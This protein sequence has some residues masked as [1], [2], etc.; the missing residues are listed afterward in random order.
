MTVGMFSPYLPK[1]FGGGERHFLTTAAYLSQQHS[2]EILVAEIPS[3]LDDRINTYQ[4]R[5]DLDLSAITWRASKLASV[6]QSAWATWR[7]TAQYDAFFYLTDGSIFANG[8]RH[9]VLHVQIPFSQPLSFV[10]R[11]KLKTWQVLN[12]NSEFT[13]KIIE[14]AWQRS[15]DVVHA[16]FVDTANIPEKLPPKTNDILT[17]GRFVAPN[18]AGQNKRQDIMVNAFITGCVEKRWPRGTTLH[19]VG[20]LEPGDHHTAFLK[21]LQKKA[22]GYPIEFH[23]DVDNQTVL[24][25]YAQSKVYWHATGFGL[26]DVKHPE[27]TEHFGMTPIEAMAWSCIPV[28]VPKGGLTETIEPNVTGLTYQTEAELLEQTSKILKFSESELAKWQSRIR[29]AAQRY[30]LPRFCQTIDT[31]I[32]TPQSL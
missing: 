10:N 1:H 26:D 2:V 5:F 13:K 16:P 20:A 23:I 22:A 27:L 6:Q 18:S 25:L 24:K 8:S 12:T 15:V 31:M 9:G 29:Q 3:D 28:V 32:E 11:L 7:E 19:V 14:S 30:S 21:S 17:V 4:K